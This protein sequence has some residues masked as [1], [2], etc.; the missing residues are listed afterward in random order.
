MSVAGNL[1][2][3]ALSVGSLIGIMALVLLVSRRCHIELE[4]QRKIVHVATGAY[5]LTLPITFGD[6]WPVMVLVAVSILVML[7]IRT[8]PSVAGGLGSVLHSVERRSFGEIYLSLAVGFLFFRSAGAP[9]LYVLPITVVTLSDAAAALVGTAYGRRHFAVEG[10]S[11]SLEGAATFFVVT[12]LAAM[13]LLLLMSDAPRGTVVVLGFLIAAFG[14]LVEAQSWQGLDN[15]FV[16]VSIHLLLGGN[17]DAQPLSLAVVAVGFLAL[18]AALVAFARVLR[19]TRHAA[20]GFA[21]LIFVILSYSAPQNALLPVTAIGA[22]LTARLRRPCFSAYPDLDLLAMIAGVGLFWLFVGEYFGRSAI[23]LFALT[24]ATATVI[25]VGLAAGTSAR[26]LVPVAMVPVCAVLSAVVA[27]NAPQ[28]SWHGS[29]WPWVIAELAVA[30]IL[31]LWRP[32][33]FDRWRSPR[34]FLATMP[35]PVALFVFKGLLA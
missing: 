25:L 30:G 11:K 2:L 29:F 5:A 23:D 27:L 10:G 13:I 20:R 4:L 33:F 12:W 31:V 6:R 14:A 26:W 32:G 17:L 19:L 28:S 9:I 15:L 22:H 8:A 18:V 3:I 16:P 7:L 21:I 1:A 24:L 35:V 34:V